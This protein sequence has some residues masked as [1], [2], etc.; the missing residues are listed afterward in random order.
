MS[1]YYMTQ[2]YVC[3]PCAITGCKNCSSATFCNY[4]DEA[5]GYYLTDGDCAHDMNSTQYIYVQTQ[6]GIIVEFVADVNLTIYEQLEEVSGRIVRV[7]S[8]LQNNSVVEEPVDLKTVN[9]SIRRPNVIGVLFESPEK[10]YIDYNYT[11]QISYVV[12]YY[13]KPSRRFLGYWIDVDD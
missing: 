8:R 9:A 10:R 7:M 4:C 12:A 13:P 3:A 11:L 6:K 2:Y 1:G 5:K